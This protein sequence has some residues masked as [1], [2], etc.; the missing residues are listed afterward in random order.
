MA[1]EIGDYPDGSLE[2]YPSPGISVAGAGVYLPA[3][4]LALQG[5]I[6]MEVEDYGDARSD[7]CRAFVPVPGPLQTV[8]TITAL[9]AFWP[10]HVGVDRNHYHLT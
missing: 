10:G 8:R 3:P 4:E 7:W 2:P 6:W 5:V 1:I 9:Q